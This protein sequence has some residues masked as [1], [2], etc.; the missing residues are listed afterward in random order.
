MREGSRKTSR[1]IDVWFVMRACLFR[2]VRLRLPEYVWRN[3]KV[4]AY[5]LS[6]YTCLQGVRD[7]SVGIVASLHSRWP[8][9]PVSIPGRLWG[10]SGYRGKGVGS[11]MGINRLECE[12]Y[13]LQPSSTEVKNTWK[14]VSTLSPAFTAWCFIKHRDDLTSFCKL[15]WASSESVPLLQQ[16][17]S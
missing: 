3:L 8:S 10:S 6:H 12:V 15:L 5:F 9:K 17:S 7:N 16:H 14:C 2:R 1:F 4:C 13:N 11:F